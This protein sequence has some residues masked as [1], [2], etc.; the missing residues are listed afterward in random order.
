M[1]DLTTQRLEIDRD[2]SSRKLLYLTVICILERHITF[3]L[4]S[5][6]NGF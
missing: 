6:G 5:R 3:K 4:T 1:I 2:L